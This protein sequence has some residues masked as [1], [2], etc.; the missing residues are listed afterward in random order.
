[1][2]KIKF[3]IRWKLS[4]GFIGLTLLVLLVVLFAVSR[5]LDNR[6]R[7]DINSNF[8]EAALI[9]KQ[10]QDIRYR[11]L[12]QTATLVADMPY[13]KAAV[14]TGDVNTVNNQIR[15]ELATLLHF[16]P[17]IS[18]TLSA[19]PLATSVDSVGLVMV[20]DDQGTPLGQLADRELPEQSIAKKPG[21][22]TALEGHFP[23]QSYIW[24]RGENYFNVI[25]IPIFIEEQVVGALSL[26]YPIRNHEAE[27]LAEVIEYEVSYLVED[28]LLASSISSLEGQKR[29]DLLEGIQS[30][31]FKQVDEEGSATIDVTM[32][33]EQWLI[34]ILPMVEATRTSSG[35][36]GYYA[37]AKSLTRALE[38]LHQLQQVIYLIG[39]GGILIAIVLGITL[40]NHLTRPISLLLDGIRRIEK[41][42][43]DQPVE[44][45][46]RDEFGRLTRTFNKLVAN[47]K[48]NLQEKEAL[49]AEIHHRVKNNLAVI[50]GLL[51]LEGDNLE[52]DRA[53]H[54]LQNSRMR[55][56]SMATIHE[57]LYKA[58]DF[59]KL[60]FGTVVTRMVESIRN[61]YDAEKVGISTNVQVEDIRLNVNQAVPCGLII[62]ELVTNAVKHAYPDESSGTINVLLEENNNRIRLQVQDFG[63]GVPEEVWSDDSQTLGFTLINILC[64]QIDA[65]LTV[66]RENGTT[67]T[68][69]FDK[70]Q[71]KGASS[72]MKI[73]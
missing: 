30:A 64:K 21:V 8:R 32:E 51:E 39:F 69:V 27:L 61:V 13:L 34:Y 17:L 68:V 42:E 47:I 60:S 54:V 6:I 40:T 72:A 38:P 20:I 1:M 33:G 15:E 59:N 12:R 11:Q 44:V 65:E 25:T 73:S 23:R 28:K 26:G 3:P 29:A 2:E 55:I 58:Q 57:M 67:V 43:Y 7:D 49:L 19:E 50:S 35:I 9:F 46:S 36:K 22:R 4:A 5:I 31:P 63:S 14:S 56:H 48:E 18:D 10:L 71:K 37:V 24:K 41:N 66:D 70:E 62:N 45:V 53:E 52:N 16:D